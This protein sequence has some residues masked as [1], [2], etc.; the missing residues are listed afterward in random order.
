MEFSCF[1]RSSDEEKHLSDAITDQFGTIL[2]DVTVYYTKKLD[3]YRIKMEHH[4]R[5][6]PDKHHYELAFIL[7][8]IYEDHPN[9]E[10]L[11]KDM[12]CRIL[13]QDLA[14]L[15]IHATSIQRWMQEEMQIKAAM[16]A[17][18][19]DLRRERDKVSIITYMIS[20]TISNFDQYPIF[21]PHSENTLT[22]ETCI[23][24]LTKSF[25][26]SSPT[27]N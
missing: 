4:Q 18:I 17:C 3:M 12:F 19:N 11:W 5:T 25:K 22:I 13:D 20:E 27:G 24:K 7:M 15:P 1:L 26:K 9:R 8:E 14:P 10:E 16:K 6:R 21:W 2:Q 23:N